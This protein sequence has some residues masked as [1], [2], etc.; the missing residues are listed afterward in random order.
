MRRC[1]FGALALSLVLAGC[2]GG[3]ASG[4][5]QPPKLVPDS[6]LTASLL[7]PADAWAKKNKPQE[8]AAP[9]VKSYS[10]PYALTG[11]GIILGVI[12]VCRPTNRLAEPKKPVV[13]KEEL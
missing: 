10:M 6:A 13:C 9:A 11:L 2:G 8:A 3:A 1:V 12:V 5:S 4:A 7:T